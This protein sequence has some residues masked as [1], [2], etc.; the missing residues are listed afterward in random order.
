MSDQRRDE[1]ERLIMLA[2]GLLDR[3]QEELVVLHLDQAVEVL[4]MVIEQ[5]RTQSR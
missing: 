2:R 5:E 1:A 3:P 4:H